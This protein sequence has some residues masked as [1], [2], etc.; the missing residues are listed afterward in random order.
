MNYNNNHYYNDKSYY[1]NQMYYKDYNNTHSNYNN[2]DNQTNQRKGYKNDRLYVYNTYKTY[3]TY[4]TFN[5]TNEKPIESIKNQENKVSITNQNLEEKVGINMEIGTNKIKS[6]IKSFNLYL[7]NDK[8]NKLT[9]K[10]FHNKNENY[11]INDLLSD[12]L[13]IEKDVAENNYYKTYD[14]VETLTEYRKK[15]IHIKKIEDIKDYFTFFK[16]TSILKLALEFSI[17]LFLEGYYPSWENNISGGMV[18]INI[19]TKDLEYYWNYVSYNFLKNY[20]EFSPKEDIIGMILVCKNNFKSEIQ[21]WIKKFDEDTKERVF[22]SLN[23]LFDSNIEEHLYCKK[24][25]N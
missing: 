12:E 6:Q 24:F 2:Y 3:N 7:R 4:N 10:D 22:K 20:S 5:L 23:K 11:S 17:I 18:T 1:Y 13:I 21:F 16:T 15:I 14:K 8:S 9:D 19:K 25:F